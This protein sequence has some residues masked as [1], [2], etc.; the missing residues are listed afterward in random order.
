MKKVLISILVFILDIIKWFVFGNVGVYVAT[1]VINF[2]N[3]PYMEDWS[4]TGH[5]RDSLFEMMFQTVAFMIIFG[6]LVSMY[7]ILFKQ[8]YKWQTLVVFVVSLVIT[9]M[10]IFLS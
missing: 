1:R 9:L 3:D 10:G 5:Y 6:L 7:K 4:S 8:N 2:F